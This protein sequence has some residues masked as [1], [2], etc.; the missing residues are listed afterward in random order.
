LSSTIIDSKLKSLIKVCKETK[1][2]RKLANVGFILINNLLNEI[3]IKLGIRPRKNN[4][5]EKIFQYMM[6]IDKI[7]IENLKFALFKQEIIKTTKII[8]LQFIKRKGFIPYQYIIKLFKIYYDL[9]KLDVPNLHEKYKDNNILISND[10]RLYSFLS[11]GNNRS[12][13]NTDKIK[14]LILHKLNEQ[15][16]YIQKNLEN[17]YNKTLFENAIYLKKIKDSIE[18]QNNNKI[19]INGLLKES[20]HYRQ[21]IEDIVGFCFVGAIILFFLLGFIVLI[22]T[23][24]FPSLTITLSS[25]LLLFLGTGALIL[26]IYW[27]Y[28]QKESR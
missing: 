23:L 3:G 19:V 24:I 9:R 2:Y 6:L 22:E 11:P 12:P 27:Y 16:R 8:E 10:L 18:T 26:F 7:L 21:S 20:I 4:S 15:E 28:F 13:K 17:C 25:L 14:P 5:E 1:N